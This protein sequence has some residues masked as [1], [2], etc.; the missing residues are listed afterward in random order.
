MTQSTPITSD[1]KQQDFRQKSWFVMRDLKRPNAKLPAYIQLEQEGIEVFTPLK[2]HIATVGGKQIR[3]RIPI[4][5]DLLF[6]HATRGEL[7]PIIARTSTLQYRYVKG[8]AYCQP[9]TVRD[10][11]MQRFMAAIR[12]DETPRYFLPE[13]ITPSMFGRRI[14]I[15]GGPLDGQE[16]NLL[17]MRGNR[18]KRLLIELPGILTVGVEV[19]PEFIQLI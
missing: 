8:G 14:R 17:S 1:A 9:M 12:T 15:I 7:D 11:D 5:S 2:W 4:I 18:K 19:N 10:V 6:T 16:A 13:E 3:R